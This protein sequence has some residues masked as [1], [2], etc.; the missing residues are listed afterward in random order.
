MA[1]VKELLKV[2]TE[3]IGVVES[4]PSS[5]KVLYNTWYYGRV[6][7]GKDYAWCMTFC[8]WVYNQVGVKLPIRTASCTT[9]M[10]EAKKKNCWVN[11]Q[12]LMPGDLILFNFQGATNVSTHCGILKSINGIKME[13]IEGNTSTTNDTNGGAVMLRNRTIKQALGAFRPKFDGEEGLDMTKEEFINSLTDREAYLLLEKAKKHAATL[14]QPAWAKKE[15]YW[16]AAEKKKIVS[17]SP[18]GL[19]KRDEMVSIMGRLGLIDK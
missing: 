15:G 16:D 7:S 18:E 9:M 13:V 19:L 5:N 10:K 14:A 17:G 11:N 2:A 1:T 12:H 8:Q 6:V 3:Q 4:P